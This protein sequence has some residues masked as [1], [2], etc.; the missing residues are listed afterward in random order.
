[1]TEQKLDWGCVSTCVQVL[2]SPNAA[3]STD[4]V[5][6]WQLRQVSAAD[7]AQEYGQGVAPCAAQATCAQVKGLFGPQHDLS[8]V[9]QVAYFDLTLR[10]KSG[11]PVVMPHTAIDLRLQGPKATTSSPLPCPIART[12]CACALVPTKRKPACGSPLTCLRPQPTLKASI[13]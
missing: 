4:I 2:D 8:Q 11:A 13:T 12:L 5:A 10:S 9:N 7:L 3:P 6:T 1:M